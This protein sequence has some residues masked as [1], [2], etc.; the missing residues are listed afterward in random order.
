MKIYLSGSLEIKHKGVLDN[1]SPNIDTTRVQLDRKLK[2]DFGFTAYDNGLISDTMFAVRA[3]ELLMQMYL[4][5][6]I[7]IE[8]EE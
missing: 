4:D 1:R 5:G 6:K 7:K 2:E 8:R 3:V